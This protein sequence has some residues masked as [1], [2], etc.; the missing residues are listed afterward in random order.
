MIKSAVLRIIKTTAFEV[1][2]PYACRLA[3]STHHEAGSPARLPIRARLAYYALQVM[4]L[5]IPLPRLMR[6]QEQAEIER[7]QI[8]DE[9][10][11]NLMVNRIYNLP[12]VQVDPEAPRRIN[13]LVP[14]FTI[15]TLS[16][17][18]FGVF[19]T[20]LFIAGQ[21]YRVRLV[22]FDNFNYDAGQ[23]RESL[24]DF[25]ALETLFER[26]EIE[27]IGARTQPLY[28]SPRDNCV[29][30]VWYSAYFAEK[31]AGLTGNRPFLYL[32]QDFEAAFYPFN[33]LYCMARRSYALRYHTLASSSALLAYLKCQALISDDPQLRSISFDNA[34]SSSLYPAEHFLQEKTRPGK[35][36]VFYSRPA[37]NRNMFEMAALALIGAFKQ[38][39]FAAE[40]WE[41]YGMGIGNTTVQLAP[42]VA[43]RQLPRMSLQE[44]QNVTKTFDLCLTL[45]SSPHPSLVP[46]DLAAAGAIVVTN[47]FETKTADYLTAISANIIPAA[48][49]LHALTQALVEGVRRTADID[50][51]LR[52]ANVRWP[53]HWSETWSAGHRALIDEVFADE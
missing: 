9:H 34:C 23:L 50:A 27:Y 47:T 42:G 5:L 40:P 32:I 25:P 8:Y 41:F 51:R 19:N 37:V 31:I 35:R 13:V 3:L 15:S 33:S 28:V 24:S 30:T 44:Y 48:P 46:I 52:H 16:A 29:A 45:M 10:L 53:R 39:A 21:G 18:F 43:V 20:A 12:D 36:L 14:A 11:L 1:F 26:L 17:G 22:L 7:P 6:D 49:E 38:G 2:G 4:S